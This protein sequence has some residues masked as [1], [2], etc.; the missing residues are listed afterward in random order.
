MH[1]PATTIEIL[2]SRL[3]RTD[4]SLN[5]VEIVLLRAAF[6]RYDDFLAWLDQHV[7]ESHGNDPAALT[8]VEM[9][10]ACRERVRRELRLVDAALA[11]LG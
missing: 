11:E 5:A 2:T 7:A 9:L 4:P 3:E 10:G 1:T 8:V 6:E